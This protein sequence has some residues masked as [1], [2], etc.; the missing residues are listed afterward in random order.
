MTTVPGF[1]DLRLLTETSRNQV[2]VARDE[3]SGAQVVL[4]VQLSDI[5]DQDSLDRFSREAQAM[6]LVS[7]HRHIATIVGTARTLD[8]RPCLVLEYYPGGSLAARL[9]G[10]GPLAPEIGVDLGIKVASALQAVHDRHLIH[11]D[12]SPTNVFL[13]RDLE[14][15]LGDF[16]I[17]RRASHEE[18]PT[19]RLTLQMAAPELL[20]GSRASV[21]TDVYALA[22]TLHTALSGE[23][24][25]ELVANQPVEEVVA[26]I[27]EENPAPLPEHVPE[28]IRRA[29][30][31]GLAR[32]PLD[33][34][35][36]ALAFADELRRA[37][38]ELG[39]DATPPVVA[40]QPS[41]P[42]ATPAEPGRLERES[43]IDRPPPFEVSDDLPEVEAIEER[44]KR[45]LY[46]ALGVL[47]GLA[48]A[49]FVVRLLFFGPSD[50]SQSGFQ[51]PLPDEKPLIGG[52]LPIPDNVVISQ[53]EGPGEVL[54]GWELDTSREG[55]RFSISIDRSGVDEQIDNHS[56]TF[57]LVRAVNP[58]DQTCV[59]VRTT[60][61]D[62]SSAQSQS[63][64]LLLESDSEVAVSIQAVA[65][66]GEQCSY[67]L[68]NAGFSPNEQLRV[69]LVGPD[70]RDVDT[71]QDYERDVTTDDDGLLEWSFDPRE[72]TPDGVYHLT[73]YRQTAEPLVRLFEVRR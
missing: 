15:V 6:Q 28:P 24:P 43:T 54:V 50:P 12:V 19:S 41:A 59:T 36:S 38:I 39:L 42:N 9:D 60:L 30:A 1:E 49:A 5:A 66:P 8:E 57:Y 3:R 63:A 31:S 33:R 56:D 14:P 67:R 16:D 71:R 11:G 37:Q 34:P 47:A 48:L 25:Y 65:C 68:I 17:T 20:S 35:R 21:S 22:A 44:S 18:I 55:I 40:L 46:I 64:C 26:H 73:I 51:Y 7:E 45:P 29:V 10:V 4:K 53:G 58:G 72:Q 69:R 27:A 62:Y 13:D 52:V 32:N 61:A 70:G 2:F 23:R